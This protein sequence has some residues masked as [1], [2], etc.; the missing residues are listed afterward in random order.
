MNAVVVITGA[1][2]GLGRALSIAFAERS[3]LSLIHIFHAVSS[4]RDGNEFAIWRGGYF[5]TKVNGGC[6][7][8]SFLFLELFKNFQIHQFTVTHRDVTDL[9]RY[10]TKLRVSVIE[11]RLHVA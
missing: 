8:R 3:Y 10:L 5:A 7:A 11:N 2:K 9:A 4:R 6:Y 1:T